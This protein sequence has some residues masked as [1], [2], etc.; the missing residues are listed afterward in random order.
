MDEKVLQMPDNGSLISK[1]VLKLC[2]LKGR[3]RGRKMKQALDLHVLYISRMLFFQDGATLDCLIPPYWRGGGFVARPCR[4]TRYLLQPLA[5]WDMFLTFAWLRRTLF[6]KNGA[7]LT[8]PEK[9]R[10][11]VPRSLTVFVELGYLIL[12]RLQGILRAI[13][14]CTQVKLLVQ[15]PW[16]M[17]I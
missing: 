7:N 6:P 8:W 17:F 12:S 2:L 10:S 9:A 16:D 3:E 1:D 5:Q 15:Q 14:T 13:S 11:E 4:H